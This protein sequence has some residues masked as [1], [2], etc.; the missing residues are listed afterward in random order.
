MNAI[1]PLQQV[2]RTYIV[3]DLVLLRDS[4]TI[5]KDSKALPDNVLLNRG[6]TKTVPAVLFFVLVSR[7]LPY[8]AG[9]MPVRNALQPASVQSAKNQLAH[10]AIMC[11][12]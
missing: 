7:L 5:L 11:I 2:Q 10:Q 8:S 9:D 1:P 3:S 12:Y 4:I 6:L